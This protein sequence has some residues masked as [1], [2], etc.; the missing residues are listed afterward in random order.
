MKAAGSPVDLAPGEILLRWFVPSLSSRIVT[1]ARTSGALGILG[2]VVGGVV[3]VPVAVLLA[4][5]HPALV[6][7]GLFLLLVL[8]GLGA[9]VPFVVQFVRRPPVRWWVTSRR[10]VTQ[11]GGQVRTFDLAAVRDLD[12]RPPS[13]MTLVTD[14]ASHQIEPVD[15]LPE[16]WGALRMGRALAPISFPAIDA[17]APAP[18]IEEV[19]CWNGEAHRGTTRLSG[20]LVFRPGRVAWV[21]ATQTSVGGAVLEVAASLAGAALGL[22]VRTIRPV[23]PIDSLFHQLVRAPSDASFDAAID[24]VVRVWG[25]FAT[26]LPAGASVSTGRGGDDVSFEV[27]GVVYRTWN[28]RHPA[29]GPIR[30]SYGR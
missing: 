19:V 4:W 9:V 25:G 22:R 21:P 23:P 29:W 30:A 1:T 12:V 11:V 8:V 28:L 5:I 14:E 10:L 26:A 24:A 3:S 2:G 15:A 16:L 27:D 18:T 7:V 6:S 17:D 20:V 13:K